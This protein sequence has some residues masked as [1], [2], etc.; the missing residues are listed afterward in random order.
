MDA[1][2]SVTP[3]RSGRLYSPYLLA[4]TQLVTSLRQFVWLPKN[5]TATSPVEHMGIWYCYSGSTIFALDSGVFKHI[6]L[7]LCRVFSHSLCVYLGCSL[8]AV[9]QKSTV[10][11]SSVSLFTEDIIEI[12]CWNCQKGEL[13]IEVL[14]GWVDVRPKKVWLWVCKRCK[15]MFYILKIISLLWKH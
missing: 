4:Q 15:H 9:P 3:P 11:P 12:F 6:R 14:A 13:C 1:C 2:E 10:L 7:S 8:S 5:V